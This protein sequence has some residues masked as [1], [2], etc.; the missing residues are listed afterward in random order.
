LCNKVSVRD[1]DENNLSFKPYILRE[2]IDT[3]TDTGFTRE[4]NQNKYYYDKNNNLINVESIFTYSSFLL[5]KKANKL[6]NKIGTID[7]ETYGSNLGLGFHKVYAGGWAVE[8]ETKI[9]Y[10]NKNKTS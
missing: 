2:W 10:K 9:F 3:K 6:D 8:G 7:F 4:Y 1:L 5:E